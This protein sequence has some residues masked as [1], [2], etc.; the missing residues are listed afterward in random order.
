MENNNEI[1]FNEALTHF[2]GGVSSPVRAFRS[3]GGVPK[4]FRKA[5]GAR[6]EDETGRCYIDLCMSWGPL[7]L[8]HAMPEV[9]DAVRD[10]IKDGLTFGAPSRH[11]IA[12]AR[13]IKKMVP[14]IK[15]MRFVSSGTEAVMSAIRTAR[16][17]TGRD[18]V[19]KFEGCY[20][21]HS[22]GML[23]K[24]GSGLATFGQPNSAGVPSSL[25]ELTLVIP[26][27]D[28]EA[29]EKVFVKHGNDL[30]AAIIEPIPANHGLLIQDTSFLLRL[31]ELC[32]KYGVILIFDEVIS[33]FRVAQG[34]AAELFNI[35]PDL[36]IYGKIIGGGM[37]VGLYGG[38]DDVMA[39]V[40][41]DGPVYQAGTLSGNPIAM[42][43][44]LATLERLTSKFYIDLNSN[45]ADWAF[46]FTKVPGLNV[47]RIGSL[48]WPAFQKAIKRA[49][50]IENKSIV[51]FNHLHSL[52]LAQGIYLPPSGFEVVFLSAAHGVKELIDFQKA[53]EALS[54]NLCQ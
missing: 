25:A 38:R 23:V 39:V 24:A 27:D 3:V 7:I 10:A 9:L 51:K 52:M 46:A 50:Q 17:F 29:M 37:P 26:L 14:F 48:I 22:D 47:S 36:V 11:E 49:D 41:P 18:R 15:K 8:G 16:G 40:S 6:F 31:R 44:G 20:H 53:V 19:L 34:G 35:I 42:A 1:L 43:A 45:S 32:T 54:S 30:A 2:P 12:L 4:F 21:G 13:R 33:G 5:Y 28:K